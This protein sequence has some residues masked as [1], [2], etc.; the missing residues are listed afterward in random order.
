MADTL[1]GGLATRQRWSDGPGL[2]EIRADIRAATRR[3]QATREAHIPEAAFLAGADPVGCLCL[4]LAEIALR[5]VLCLPIGLAARVARARLRRRLAQVP[6]SGRR[7]AIEMLEA[8]MAGEGRE[9]VAPLL[10]RLRGETAVV[11]AAA[12]A[13]RGDEVAAGG[14]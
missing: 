5:I 12:P 10:R 14:L 1:S 3:I 6:P 11:P 2:A 13:G 7:N 9:I 4:V 8:E